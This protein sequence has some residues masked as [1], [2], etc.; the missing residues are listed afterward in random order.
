MT[1]TP[2]HK[3]AFAARFRRHA[4]GWRSQPAIQRVKEAVA[5]IKAASRQDRILAAEGAVVLLEKLSPA[6]ERVDSSSGAIGTAVNNAID[7]L[8]KVIAGAPVDNRMRGSWLDRLWQAVEEDGI[9]YLELLPEQWG[10]LCG[11]PDLAGHWADELIGPLRL[12]WAEDRKAGGGYFKGTAACLS[13][14]FAAGRFA[15]I[16]VLLDL[17]PH[18]FWHYRQWGVR[19]LSAMARNDEA[20]RYAEESRG[21]NEPDWAISAACEQVLLDSGR[22]NEAYSRYAT[23][24]NRKTT[25][26]AT[27][28]AI[29]RKYPHKEM[30][31]ILTDLVNA[32]PGNEGKWFAAAKSAGLYREAIELANLTP[33]DPKTLTRA[34]EEKKSSEPLFAVET[35]MAALRW[36]AAGYGYEIT[37]LD[38]HKACRCTME[39]ARFAGCERETRERIRTLVADNPSTNPLIKKIL[40]R[41]TTNYR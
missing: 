20:L 32:S 4:F 9:P 15:E 6:L 28:R 35:G 33:C 24:A 23:S 7:A 27:F 26:L 18:K 1:R 38:V 34:A 19:A 30:R 31:T 29:A 22:I 25:Y 37:G 11:T 5:E 41:E 21:L 17:A 16:L 12:A 13:A 40:D 14:L 36:L 2:Q 10:S 3:W 8:V 39:A